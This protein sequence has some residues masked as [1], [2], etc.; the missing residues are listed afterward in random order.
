MVTKGDSFPH[1]CQ[2][3]HMSVV[4]PFYLMLCINDLS[5]AIL[6]SC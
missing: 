5:D 1:H 4:G 2:V 3:P 6:L